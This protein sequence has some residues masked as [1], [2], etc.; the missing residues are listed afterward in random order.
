ME[1][2]RH[3]QNQAAASVAAHARS[4][5][6]ALIAM[7][8]ASRQA[9]NFDPGRP[10]TGR[11]TRWRPCGGPAN[12]AEAGD[13]SRSA[14]ARSCGRG[15]QWPKSRARPRQWTSCRLRGTRVW[16]AAESILEVAEEAHGAWVRHRRDAAKSASSHDGHER[17]V[18]RAGD[19]CGFPIHVHP[20]L[21]FVEFRVA[22]NHCRLV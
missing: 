2:C 4:L 15:P 7:G 11:R 19:S 5:A 17:Q 14:S 20:L 6:L 13:R 9:M 21:V 3:V 8:M 18:K 12:Q 1:S 22:V 10:V 16:A